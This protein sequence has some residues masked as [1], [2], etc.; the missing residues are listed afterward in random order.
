MNKYVRMLV[1]VAI[2]GGVSGGLLTGATLA[3]GAIIEDNKEAQ[4]K[5]EI[6]NAH[7]VTFT[8][9]TIHETFANRVDV[10]SYTRPYGDRSYVFNFYVDRTSGVITYGFDNTFGGGVWGPIIGLFTLQSDWATIVRISV[11]QQ[12]ETPGLGAIVATR[13]YL[14]QFEGKSIGLGD[15]SFEII[16]GLDPS[17]A[18]DN[19]VPSITGATGTSSRFQ[20]I[21][22]AA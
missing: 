7:G 5:A 11:L 3:T 2:L 16:K 21:I 17:Q 20:S 1:F 18:G 9:T 15:A 8:Q 13:T 19:Q 4:L 12:E 14:N 10:Y 22:N 6:L